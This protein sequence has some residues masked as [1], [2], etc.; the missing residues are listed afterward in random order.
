MNDDA[1]DEL[2][3]RAARRYNAPPEAPREAMWARIEA[4]RAGREAAAAV[5]HDGAAGPTAPAEPRAVVPLRPRRVSRRA[6]WMSGIAAALVVGFALGHL[7]WGGERSGSGGPPSQVAAQPAA[8]DASPDRSGGG[9]A[10]EAATERRAAA[11]PTSVAGGTPS[12]GGIAD[13]RAAAREPVVA[14]AAARGSGEVGGTAAARMV[15]VPRSAVGEERDRL[16]FFRVAAQSTLVQAEVLLT[17][18][19]TAPAADSAEYRRLAEWGRQVLSSTRLLLDSPAAADPALGPLLSDLELVLVQVVE[20]ADDR[21]T[22]R[23]LIDGAVR[24]RDVLP[25]L[26]SAVPPSRGVVGS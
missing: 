17:S 26:R 25:R 8:V 3:A 11:P 14:D 19:R 22:G 20:L 5:G 9:P 21:E 6:L 1:F 24:Q 16:A 2:L 15:A 12:L 10:E 7:R 18:V 23:E 13:G 4:A